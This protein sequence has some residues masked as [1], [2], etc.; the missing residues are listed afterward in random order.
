MELKSKH[1]KA[2]NLLVYQGYNHVQVA[3]ELNVN[4]AT[5]WRW[6]QDASFCKELRE[7]QEKYNAFLGTQAISKLYELMQDKTVSAS[8]KARIAKDMAF[9]GGWKPTDKIEQKLEAEGFKIEISDAD[10]KDEEK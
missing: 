3:N 1:I 9:I 7:E 5:V 6:F 2:I 4:E 8:V 10:E